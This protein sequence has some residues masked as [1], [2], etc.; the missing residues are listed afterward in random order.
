MFYICR[1]IQNLTG[2]NK[3]FHHLFI[4][5]NISPEA[6]WLYEIFSGMCFQSAHFRFIYRHYNFKHKCSTL[7]IQKFRNKISLC[8]VHP[9]KKKKHWHQHGD[10][11]SKTEWRNLHRNSPGQPW[12]GRAW[13]PYAESSQRPQINF[14]H[15]HQTKGTTRMDTT[16]STITTKNKERGE[17][18][19]KRT[20]FPS[21]ANVQLPPRMLGDC[22]QR[23]A[24]TWT[25]PPPTQPRSTHLSEEWIK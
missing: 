18:E 1:S 17:R 12:P 3:Y 15:K 22:D 11:S 9:E 25:P 6:S 24:Q 19:K 10:Q 16:S 5:I 21:W 13:R 8:R 2:F 20:V 23:R 14:L 7:I 4:K